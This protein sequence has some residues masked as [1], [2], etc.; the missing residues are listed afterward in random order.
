LCRN[1]GAIL[2]EIEQAVWRLVGLWPSAAQRRLWLP[3]ALQ[4]TN[5]IA[6]CKLAI[7]TI[8]RNEAI[9]LDVLLF[10]VPGS[11]LHQAASM[12]GVRPA[13]V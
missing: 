5:G 1:G 7:S 13:S 3:E 8:V 9:Y 10:D 6:E 4:I 2:Y 12:N 11:D